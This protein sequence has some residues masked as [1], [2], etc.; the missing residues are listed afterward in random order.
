[1]HLRADAKQAHVTRMVIRPAIRAELSSVGAGWRKRCLG[2]RLWCVGL[3]S[4]RRGRRLLSEDSS[5]SLRDP[6]GLSSEGDGPCNWKALLS[7]DSSLSSEVLPAS[8]ASSDESSG[9]GRLNGAIS[10]ICWDKWRMSYVSDPASSMHIRH[11][12][13]NSD[14]FGRCFRP[15]Q[16]HQTLE[17]LSC[18]CWVHFRRDEKRTARVVHSGTI[19]T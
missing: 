5:M 6:W 1:M 2:V 9:R 12:V 14:A 7:T 18:R 13:A 15:F 19:K 16:Y 8:S 3:R 11:R 10:C 4:R 17:W